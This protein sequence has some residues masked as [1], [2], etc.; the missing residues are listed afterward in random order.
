MKKYMWCLLLY[1]PCQ[2][3]YTLSLTEKVLRHIYLFVSVYGLPSVA[4]RYDQLR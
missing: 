1:L 2:L 4:V 3:T